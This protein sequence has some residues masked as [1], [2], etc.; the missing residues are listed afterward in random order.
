[1]EVGDTG[2]HGPAVTRSKSKHLLPSAGL[3]TTTTKRPRG[4][5][6]VI[7]LPTTL[8]DP[9]DPADPVVPFVNDPVV[10]RRSPR[11]V[12]TTLAPVR[13]TKRNL[14]PSS[15]P[16]SLPPPLPRHVVQPLTPEQEAELLKEQFKKEDA[17][18]AEARNKFIVKEKEIVKIMLEEPK[19]Q[20]RLRI[21]VKKV[22]DQIRKKKMIDAVITAFQEKM[23]E[24]KKVLIQEMELRNEI[25]IKEQTNRR[26]RVAIDVAQSIEKEKEKPSSIPV[27]QEYNLMQIGDFILKQ[28]PADAIS[29]LD[30]FETL[31]PASQKEIVDFIILKCKG[32]TLNANVNEAGPADDVYNTLGIKSL[33]L[34]DAVA[35]IPSSYRALIVCK[36]EPCPVAGAARVAEWCCCIESDGVFSSIKELIKG[37]DSPFVTAHP[38]IRL[39]INQSCNYGLKPVDAQRVDGPLEFHDPQGFAAPF[40]SVIIGDDV[41]VYSIGPIINAESILGRPLIMIRIHNYKELDYENGIYFWVYPSFSEGGA[42]RV[43]LIIGGGQ[44]MKG[45]DYTLTT[46][47]I[48]LLQVHI[49]KYYAEH[50]VLKQG[51]GFRPTILSTTQEVICF[52]GEMIHLQTRWVHDLIAGRGLNLE[53][54]PI[55]DVPPGFNRHCYTFHSSLEIKDWLFYGIPD[56]ESPR[57]VSLS[58]KAARLAYHFCRENQVYTGQRSSRL[59]FPLYCCLTTIF[60]KYRDERKTDVNDFFALFKRWPDTLFVQ[61][62]NV[63]PGVSP[64]GYVVAGTSSNLQGMRYNIFLE[65]L[66]P[67]EFVK[68]FKSL[69][70][71]QPIV[72]PDPGETF[73]MIGRMGRS[74]LLIKKRTLLGIE[75]AQLE[76]CLMVVDLA[77][78]ADEINKILKKR[79]RDKGPN[80]LIYPREQEAI[81]LKSLP[82]ALDITID[83]ISEIFFSHPPNRLKDIQKCFKMFIGLPDCPWDNPDQFKHH[84]VI[85]SLD[86]SRRLDGLITS[87]A[88]IKDSP[89]YRL[90]RTLETGVYRHLIMSSMLDEYTGMVSF[91]LDIPPIPPSL[92][93]GLNPRVSCAFLNSDGQYVE[94]PGGFGEGSLGNC[95]FSGVFQHPLFNP[96][97]F[98]ATRKS[99]TFPDGILE[100]YIRNP[101]IVTPDLAASHATIPVKVHNKM[102]LI[103]LIFYTTTGAIQIV[104]CV[105]STICIA[106]P[107]GGPPSIPFG[108][109]VQ[110]NVVSI[111]PLGPIHV[112]PDGSVEVDMSTDATILATMCDYLSLGCM[113]ASKKGEYSFTSGSPQFFDYFDIF[114]KLINT[115]CYTY[116]SAYMSP[117]NCGKDLVM[118]HFGRVFKDVVP[119]PNPPPNL[120]PNPISSAIRRLWNWFPYLDH[121]QPEVCSPRGPLTPQIID[122]ELAYG[123]WNMQVVVQV[124]FDPILSVLDGR[125]VGDET[126]H[127]EVEPATPGGPADTGSGSDSDT[128]TTDDSLYQ[129]LILQT[130]SFPSQDDSAASYKSQESMGSSQGSASSNSRGSAISMSSQGSASSLEPALGGTY[131]GGRGRTNRKTRKR[132][133]K[134]NRRSKSKSKSKP[135]HSNIRRRTRKNTDVSRTRTRTRTKTKTKTMKIKSKKF[136]KRIY[137]YS[138][139]RTAQRMA[140]KYLGRTKTAKLYPARNPAKKYMVFDPKNNKWVNF[141]QMG[142]E[143]YTKHHDKTR[144][145]NYLTRTKGMLGDWKSNKYSANNLSRRILWT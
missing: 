23:A 142:Y 137:L 61:G 22:M 63:V 114:F 87:I 78:A 31:S 141:G 1:M 45:P 91:P 7:I 105:S 54:D 71:V 121:V 100:R 55:G 53:A 119:N 117:F 16:P 79:R 132:K 136:P 41:V 77:T 144:R 5:R 92:V 4:K 104:V 110:F 74:G 68:R 44:F 21:A 67:L 19:T 40:P 82:K 39:M 11:R 75:T 8:P 72:T 134:T 47:I 17:E 89:L 80:A 108:V 49:N 116:V 97:I 52:F 111:G 98:S 125:A 128:S 103:R 90:I 33:P 140:Y 51:P 9:A 24:T 12:V 120:I 18:E 118:K 135:K 6:D 126:G 115:E 93:P 29:V 43:F 99:M 59:G 73:A 96:Y 70:L 138:T 123:R 101:K 38:D 127:G 81:I 133:Y 131:G 66:A 130:L 84:I 27:F 94:L 106:S 88:I 26:K 143:D 50:F 13:P 58:T 37:Q 14:T 102:F 60:H 10:G 113:G 139:P 65:H 122:E 35:G 48:D 36:P 34:H 32:A 2:R 85:K 76:T 129:Q 107:M 64:V 46:F 25:E 109:D 3:T 112:N 69:R 83:K 15:L 62:C 124:F 95:D 42:S 86:I 57:L 28:F 30:E 145:K 56:V 20:P